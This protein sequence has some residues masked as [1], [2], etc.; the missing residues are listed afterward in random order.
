MELTYCAK[1]EKQ[2]FVKVKEEQVIFD[3]GE[4]TFLGRT[5]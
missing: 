4:S 3:D 1:F 2:P 5:G